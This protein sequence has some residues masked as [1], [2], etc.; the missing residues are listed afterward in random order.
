[1]IIEKVFNLIEEISSDRAIDLLNIAQ[2][3]DISVNWITK[4][5]LEYIPILGNRLTSNEFD[6]IASQLG[7]TKSQLSIIQ[8][9][10][11]A[12]NNEEVL[13]SIN[14]FRKINGN[15]NIVIDGVRSLTGDNPGFINNILDKIESVS[16]VFPF[17]FLLLMYLLIKY[18][19]RTTV[20]V[21]PPGGVYNKLA[22]NTSRLRLN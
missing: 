18:R 9:Q 16:Y 7:V 17:L 5:L 11:N 21:S 6:S 8:N 14:E 19:K 10:M 3:K 12:G 20:I 22:D 4:K 15:D 2:T 13:K 1:V